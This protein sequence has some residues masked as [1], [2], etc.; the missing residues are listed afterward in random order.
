LSSNPERR[1]IDALYLPRVRCKKLHGHRR[2]LLESEIRNL[3]RIVNSSLQEERDNQPQNSESKL[4][5][6]A[7]VDRTYT[8]L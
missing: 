5:T 7:M 8:E 1:V 6:F 4:R 2:Q 3:Q